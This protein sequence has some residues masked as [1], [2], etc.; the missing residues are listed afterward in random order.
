MLKDF[1]CAETKIKKGKNWWRWQAQQLAS[2][3]CDQSVMRSNS[4]TDGIQIEKSHC[5]NVSTSHVNC[6]VQKV[7]IKNGIGTYYT[8]SL[9]YFL[10]KMFQV[11]TFEKGGS[12][13][14]VVM[15]GDLCSEGRGFKSQHRILDY[16]DIFSRI[17]VV[18]IVMFAWK[19]KNKWKRGRGWPI[20]LKEK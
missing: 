1:V 15:G 6:K 18:K 4:Y 20:F 3:P 2:S 19:D 8:M 13:G 17:F 12:P 9:H 16:H 5:V 10:Q 14:L 7:A 11:L